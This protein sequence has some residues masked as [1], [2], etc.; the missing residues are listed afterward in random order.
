MTDE[1]IEALGA[2]VRTLEQALDH[3]LKTCAK[4]HNVDQY[5]LEDALLLRMVAKR[6]H[7]GATKVVGKLGTS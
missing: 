3:V 5:H 6:L 7:R 1:R 4:E 2:A